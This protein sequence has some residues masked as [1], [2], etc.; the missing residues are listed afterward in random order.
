LSMPSTISS[1][2]SVRNAIHACGS[3][4]SSVIGPAARYGS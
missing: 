3:V 2:D 1:A 4:N